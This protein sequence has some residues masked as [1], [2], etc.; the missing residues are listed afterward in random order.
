MRRRFVTASLL[1]FGLGLLL[2]CTDA[3]TITGNGT[4]RLSETG[5]IDQVRLGF[6]LDTDGNVSRG[7][8]A[9]GFAPGDPI[10]LSVHVTAA[11]E[12]ALLDITIREASTLRA[13]WNE[14]RP[15]P[16][17]RS[18]Q[19]F[20]IGRELAEGRYRAEPAFGGVVVLREFEVRSRAGRTHNVLYAGS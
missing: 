5:G 4:G 2:A 17:G 8:T 10:H 16:A 11:H 12:G 14:R 20:E 3:T 9:L 19:T 6:G 18:V 13:A 15:L 1:G 7:C